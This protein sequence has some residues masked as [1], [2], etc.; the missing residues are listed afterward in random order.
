[1]HTEALSAGSSASHLFHFKHNFI[2]K[3]NYHVVSMGWRGQTTAKGFTQKMKRQTNVNGN[4]AKRHGKYIIFHRRQKYIIRW[5][6]RKVSRNQRSG[7]KVCDR[8]ML[9]SFALMENPRV[10]SAIP[11][12]S[13]RQGQVHISR[14][15]SHTHPCI[16]ELREM[17]TM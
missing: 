3:R 10:A 6:R 7:N 8:T 14:H 2:T 13:L 12:Q 9:E 16:R 15:H 4:Y 5:E 17:T 11:R 1:M